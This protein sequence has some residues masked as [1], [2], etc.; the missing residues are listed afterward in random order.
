MNAR[1]LATETSRSCLAFDVNATITARAMREKKSQSPVVLVFVDGPEQDY[2]DK[3]DNQHVDG[4]LH[5]L[6]VP[7]RAP[8]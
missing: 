3:T 4:S 5:S 6:V 1:S 7:L 2:A 8:L